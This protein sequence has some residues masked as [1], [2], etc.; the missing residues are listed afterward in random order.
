MVAGGIYERTSGAAG[1]PL[2]GYRRRTPERTVLYELVSTYRE[3][4][5][6]H[7]R[8]IDPNGFGMPRHVE[9]ELEAFLRCGLLEHGFTRVRCASCHDE[10]LVA[11]SCKCR[12][13]CPSCTSRRMAETAA[14][15]VDRLLPESRYRQWV[16][17]V[18]KW[19]RLRLAREASFASWVNRL[20]VQAIARWQRDRARARGVRDGQTGAVTFVQRFG[21]LLQLS[22]HY[23]LVVPDG[24]FVIDEVT[25]ELSLVPLPGPSE[26]EVLAILDRVAARIAARL[27]DEAGDS[28]AVD[29][30]DTPPDLWSQVQAEATTPWRTRSASGSVV[31]GTEPGRAWSEGF[32]LHAGVVIAE[33]DRAALERLCRYGARPAFAHGRLAWTDDGRISYRLKR[34][35][36]DGRSELVLEP[37]AFLRRL[38]GIIP[39]P[40]RHLVKYH[41]IFGR[42]AKHR[43][44]LQRLVPVTDR[45]PSTC[46]DPTRTEPTAVASLWSSRRIPWADLLRRVFAED[47]L[48]CVCG[49]RRDVVALVTDPPLARTILDRLGLAHPPAVFTPRGP[50]SLFDVDPTPAFEPDPPAPDE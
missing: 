8:E 22:V 24:V 42:A 40:R 10:L 36:H 21:G 20:I 5:L 17:T 37:I 32:S 30:L 4:M 13:L 38:C 39:P 46:S 41:G 25:G 19:L 3:S 50:P 48:A 43:G 9:R 7:L 35:W 33:T 14:H 15:V 11:F 49:G 1:Q 29:D 34:R 16:L 45:R 18:P 23:H 26:A 44:Q 12:G 31:R 28:C 2:S 6:Q 27:A 47:V